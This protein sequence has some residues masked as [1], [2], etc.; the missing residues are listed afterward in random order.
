[1]VVGS[2][3]LL[4]L[5]FA[6]MLCRAALPPPFSW[7]TVPVFFH[8]TNASGLWSAAALA[9]FAAFP[10]ITFD[11]WQGSANASDRRP[12]EARALD[13]ARQVRAALGASP[14]LLFYQ[15]SLIDFPEFSTH[16]A[17]VR[18]ASLRAKNASGDDALVLLPQALWLFDAATAAGASVPVDACLALAGSDGGAT[19]DGCFFDRTSTCHSPDCGFGVEAAMTPA[20]F[21]AFA[22]G[23]AQQLRAATAA[24]A[25]RGQLAL[26]NN[27]PVATRAPAIML[28]DFGANESCVLM[29][30]AAAA[31]GT[32]VEAHA[33]DVVSGSDAHC[34]RTTNA[35]S[36]FLIGAGE[37]AY[38]ACS[39]GQWT[40][41]PDWPRVPDPWLDARP[42]Y[43][44]PLGA[45]LGAA[46]RDAAG[47]WSRN[48]S[49]GT[50]VFFDAVS[51]AGRIAW[52]DGVV[53]Q[54]E[55]GLNEDACIW[56][57]L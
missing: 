31:A 10:L 12:G 14:T 20:Q 17:L 3:R 29:L 39:P 1:M 27:A 41:S 50:R 47:G 11:K 54:G 8:S 16:G 13:A 2:R 57:A 7:A 32:L 36:A 21:A 9:R 40:S 53:D 6:C 28:E 55:G 19:Y 15:N 52:A 51:N 24:L 45:P 56:A 35:L 25:A 30:R 34:N 5:G 33:G 26:W 46:V 48:F 4:V 38:F 49:S 42:E 18:D 22:A 43:A 23:H 44:R 37:R